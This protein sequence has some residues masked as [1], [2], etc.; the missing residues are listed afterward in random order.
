MKTEKINK[1]IRSAKASLAVEDL[2]VTIEEENLIQS[3]LKGE[4]SES[5]FR[6]RALQ[7]INE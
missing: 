3:R 5:E 4:I 2:H 1:A 6:K 7:L